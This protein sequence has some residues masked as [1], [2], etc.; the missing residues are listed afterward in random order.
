MTVEFD[1]YAATYD[2]GQD[3]RLKRWLGNE[4]DFTAVKVRWLTY[5]L[6]RVPLRVLDYGCGTG[7]FLQQWSE[8]RPMDSLVGVDP[9][10]AMRQQAKQRNPNLL[11][12][13]R[14]SS[15]TEKSFHL[16]TLSGVLHHVKPWERGQV[17]LECYRLLKPGGR[18]CIFEHNARNPLVRWVVRNTAIDKNASLLDDEEALTRCQIAGFI[19]GKREYLM[20]FPPSWRVSAW[21]ERLLGWLP[22]G[23]QYAVMARKGE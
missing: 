7:E 16:I 8:R 5:R 6:P 12:F 4:S 1:H 15:F 10:T 20:F 23:G 19:L 14:G 18:L 11:F 17:L 2:G 3:N 22:L 21:V 13:I 9:S